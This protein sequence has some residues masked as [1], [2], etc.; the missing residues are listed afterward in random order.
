ME[1]LTFFETRR[2]QMEYVVPLINDLKE[3]LGD[4]AVLEALEKVSEL[5]LERAEKQQTI[6]F[7]EMGGM[8]D[9]YAAGDAL[10]YEVIASSADQFDV[11][12]QV[13][14]YAQ[15]MEELGGRDFGHLLICSGDF[16]SA[17]EMGLEL[18]RSK[19]VMQGA[20]MCDF[21]YKP[22]GS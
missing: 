2:I 6:D 7:A 10:E 20:G 21:R 18:S 1:D 3:V 16:V 4:E 15:M 5:R 17:K 19:T 14:R 11:D 13:C 9:Y 8:V 22:D 12:V